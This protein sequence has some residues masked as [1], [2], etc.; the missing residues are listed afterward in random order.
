MNPI[1]DDKALEY[2]DQALRENEWAPIGNGTKAMIAA[3]MGMVP[4]ATALIAGRRFSPSLI[5]PS[6]ALGAAGY[7]IPSLVNDAI[8]KYKDNP[9]EGRAFLESGFDRINMQKTSGIGS[10]ALKYIGQGGYDFA[11]GIIAPIKG[12]TMGETALS[13]ASKAVAGYGALQAG[14]YVYNKSRKPNYVNYLR[15]QVLAGNIKPEELNQYDLDSVKNL[16]M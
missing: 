6:L 3:I 16:G 9:D 11:R 2:A 1:L 12:K 8:G 5:A 4:M 10:K 15:N 13:V 7:A 14:K